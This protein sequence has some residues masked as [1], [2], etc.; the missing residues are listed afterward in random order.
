MFKLANTGGWKEKQV[1]CPSCG[2]YLTTENFF[3]NNPQ[4]DAINVK[5]RFEI[6]QYNI[7][8]R[9][10]ASVFNPFIGKHSGNIKY[11]NLNLEEIEDTG[12]SN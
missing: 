4:K 12:K 10:V 2:K 6:S 9:H 11:Y 5:P 3:T 7:I 1:P 8:R